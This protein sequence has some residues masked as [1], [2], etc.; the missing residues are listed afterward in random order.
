MD[1]ERPDRRDEDS[2]DEEP[3]VQ[4]D[5]GPAVMGLPQLPA[6]AQDKTGVI[7]HRIW[8]ELRKINLDQ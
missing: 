1:E 8:T 5:Q 7:P 3:A 6:G 4:E 2:V